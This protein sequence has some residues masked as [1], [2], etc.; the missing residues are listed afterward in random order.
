MA[1]PFSQGLN[2]APDQLAR[3]ADAYDQAAIQTADILSDLRKWAFLREAWAHDAVSAEVA[4]HY[5]L[6]VLSGPASSYQAIQRY[7]QE[8][9]EIGRVLRVMRAAYD[10]NE[11]EIESRLRQP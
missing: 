5:N 3:L 8:L 1:P 11:A 4:S 10:T 6:Q 9:Q 7:R 2:V